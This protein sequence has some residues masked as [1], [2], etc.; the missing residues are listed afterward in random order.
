MC[1][2]TF[3]G[4]FLIL[5]QTELKFKISVLRNNLFLTTVPL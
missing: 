5:E 2:E 3:V 1:V 4:T